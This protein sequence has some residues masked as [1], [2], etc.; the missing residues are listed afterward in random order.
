VALVNTA[1]NIVKKLELKE[2]MPN[3]AYDAYVQASKEDIINSPSHYT[4]RVPEPINVIRD[5]GLNFCLGNAVKYIA[6]AG[7]KGGPEKAI[8]DLE[9]ARKYL[10]FEIERLENLNGVL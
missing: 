9:K 6:R 4:S 8:E 1:W 5:W 3:N 2:P 10:E 7:A